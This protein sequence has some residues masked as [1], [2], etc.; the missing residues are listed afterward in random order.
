MNGTRYEIKVEGRLTHNWCGWFEGLEMHYEI[1]GDGKVETTIL[2]VSARDPAYLHGVL[3]Q[4]GALNLTL[5]Q[6][7]RLDI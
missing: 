1:G 4:I 3:A 7:K 6:I 2:T 5:V